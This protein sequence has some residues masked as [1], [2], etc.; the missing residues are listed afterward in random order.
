MPA[1]TKKLGKG[2]VDLLHTAIPTAISR[3]WLL[4]VFF[5]KSICH[6]MLIP[7]LLQI[8]FSMFDEVS[9]RHMHAFVIVYRYKN[10]LR[11]IYKNRSQVCLDTW[12]PSRL[13]TF[14]RIVSCH[15]SF[16]LS[17]RTT[18]S[19]PAVAFHQVFIRSW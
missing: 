16:S 6:S 4:P 9:S 5:P 7:S 13:T 15:L 2:G 19:V 8:T 1:R 11:L 12:R 14:D 3:L 17:P 18:G 10:I